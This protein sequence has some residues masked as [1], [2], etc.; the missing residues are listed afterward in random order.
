MSTMK[1]EAE[2]F[3]RYQWIPALRS[4]TY[5]QAPHTLH[6]P[7]S[8]SYCCLGV[9]CAIYPGVIE[10]P[11]PSM[12]H[13]QFSYHESASDVALP[14]ELAI[15]LGIASDGEFF[16]SYQ[17]TYNLIGLN[18]NGVTFAEIADFIENEILDPDSE[19]HFV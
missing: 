12:T 16:P 15:Q 1:P 6:S 17:G 5:K 2:E 13:S 11:R 4:G 19:Y 10:I 14:Q 8:N 9:L 3:I 7:N 18:D